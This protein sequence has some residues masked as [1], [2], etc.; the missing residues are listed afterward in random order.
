MNL[1]SSQKTETTMNTEWKARNVAV[2]PFPALGDNTIY[3]R[4][5]QNLVGEGCFVTFY[6]DMLWPA[7]DL[8]PWLSIEP[9]SE[10]AI[11]DILKRHDLVIGDVLAKSIASIGLAPDQIGRFDNF[12]AVTAKRFPTGFQQLATPNWLRYSPG[13]LLHRSFCP[14]VQSG[15]TMVDW[16]DQYGRESLGIAPGKAPPAVQIP[17]NWRSDE[18]ADTR[19]VIFPT[20]P[21]PKKNYSPRGFSQL[22]ERLERAGWSV[23]IVCL[24]REQDQMTN[25]FNPRPV[26]SFL[27]LRELIR[28]LLQTKAVISN[29]SGGGH[30]AS[31]LG[32]STFT[33][34]KKKQ[35]FVWRPGFNSHNRVIS[36]LLT[37]KLPGNKIWRPFIP[38]RQITRELGSPKIR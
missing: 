30:L 20:T 33:I 5:A 24:P 4:L 17:A 13:V 35:D 8:F 7:A 22:A 31:M 18:L 11:Q 27:S 29:D 3:L 36:P 37:L 15:P 10:H 9:L 23:D 32:L 14:G 12:V 21:N 25:A 38:L 19:I 26:K 28:H 2:I 6:S 1:V 34:T 16:V